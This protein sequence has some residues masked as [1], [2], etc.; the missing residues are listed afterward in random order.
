METQLLT[1]IFG[2]WSKVNN[3]FED[4]RKVKVTSLRRR[5][6]LGAKLKASMVVTNNDTLSHLEDYQ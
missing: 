3:T 6:L 2:K 1:E 4:L 5:N